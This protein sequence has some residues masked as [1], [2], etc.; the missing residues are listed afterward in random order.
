MNM[1]V[2]IVQG[3][4]HNGLSIMLGLLLQAAERAIHTGKD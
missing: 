2:K 1:Y 3:G 4:K